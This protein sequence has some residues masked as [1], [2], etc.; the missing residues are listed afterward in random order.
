M[1]HKTKIYINLKCIELMLGIYIIIKYNRV[2]FPSI[3]KFGHLGNKKMKSNRCADF[4]QLL[5]CALEK[6][7]LFWVKIY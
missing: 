3:P 6:L 7:F 4:L 1:L 2:R 5:R